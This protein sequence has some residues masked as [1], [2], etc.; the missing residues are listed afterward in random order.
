[1]H[2]IP[3]PVP[4]ETP[5]PRPGEGYGFEAI[6][7]IDVTIDTAIRA[8]DAAVAAS[9]VSFV[10]VYGIR[11]A[12]TDFAS[13]YQ[14]ARDIALKDAELSAQRNLTPQMLQLGALLRVDTP[15][16]DRGTPPSEFVR[17]HRSLS[18]APPSTVPRLEVRATATVTYAIKP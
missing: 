13:A 14:E 12:L 6:R 9:S 16:N 18:P 11:Y 17:W 2:G 1:V 3:S 15:R 5:P 4:F 8:G 7:E 10:D